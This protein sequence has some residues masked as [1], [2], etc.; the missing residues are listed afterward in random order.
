[1][2]A[3]TIELYGTDA[4]LYVG[5]QPSRYK[6][7]IRNPKPGFE[8]GWHSWESLDSSTVGNSLVVDENYTGEAQHMLRRV[9]AWD[10]DNTSSLR[11]AEA[12]ITVLDA[13]YRSHN[14]GKRVS[15]ET[16]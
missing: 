1:V 14:E 3:W 4:T 7:Y 9:R 6:L 16:R 13:M 2:E 15:V 12:V 11:E 8:I 5:I 10:T